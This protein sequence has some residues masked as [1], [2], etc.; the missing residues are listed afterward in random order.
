MKYLTIKNG[1]D[2]NI[3]GIPTEDCQA[4][5]TPEKVALLPERIPF[6]KPRL[7]V[8][9]GSLVNIGTPLIEDKRNTAIKFLSPG[10]GIVESIK[11]EPRRVI[12][13]I[14]IDLA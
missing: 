3:E 5:K 9:Q 14:I 6:I 4:I 8:E 1:Y 10:G 12:K 13:E 11:F 7:L 2:I